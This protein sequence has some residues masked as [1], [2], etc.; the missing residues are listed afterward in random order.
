MTAATTTIPV[1]DAAAPALAMPTRLVL[2]HPS[3]ISADLRVNSRKFPPPKSDIKDLID[4]ILKNGQQQPV[5]VT[6]LAKLGAPADGHRYGLVFGF[7]RLLAITTIN[8]RELYDVN[9]YPEGFPIRAEVVSDLDARG[10]YLANVAE[11]IERSE[12]SAI[13][14]AYAMDRLKAE[15]G[16]SQTEVARCFHTSA[17][18]V[19]LRLKLLDIPEKLQKM[20]HSGARSY[21]E[22]LEAL[23]IADDS[24]RERMLNRLM[25]PDKT[26][27]KPGTRAA[28]RKLAEDDENEN[29]GAAGAGVAS[30]RKKHRAR[31]LGEIRKFWEGL[32]E[33][34]EDATR[35]GVNR[36]AE[37]VVRFNHGGLTERTLT[38]ALRAYAR[39][40]NQGRAVR[41]GLNRRTPFKIVKAKRG[42]VAL[43]RNRAR[44]E[45]RAVTIAKRSR[46]SRQ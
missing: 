1:S 9:V 13:D 7:Q 34:G 37:L 24:M 15:F 19:S 45:S 12:L 4:S 42:H 2:L 40:P 36:L 35:P 46:R 38:K 30:K 17:T 29:G 11:N 39:L 18:T 10:A 26:G 23:S 28:A 27:G 5:K 16:M 3:R 14:E 22:V 31:S 32:A 6:A 20:V 8:E 41:R 43:A 44:A 21:S 25:L 33:G